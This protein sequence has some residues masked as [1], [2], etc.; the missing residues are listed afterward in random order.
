[1]NKLSI[2]RKKYPLTRYVVCVL[3]ALSV[4]ALKWYAP[5]FTNQ[6]AEEVCAIIKGDNYVF[7]GNEEIISGINLVTAK[8]DKGDVV[9]TD[10]DFTYSFYIVKSK[11]KLTFSP[12]TLTAK[13]NLKA[14]VILKEIVSNTSPAPFSVVDVEPSEKVDGLLKDYFRGVISYAFTECQKR[15]VDIFDLY[16]GFYG[17]MGKKWKENSD[18]Y[19]QNSSLEVDAKVTYY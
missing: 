1:M 2:F 3:A 7:D 8:L 6:Y 16:G 13:V 4:L 10:G 19:L 5:E 11:S 14:D 12:E 18:N 9:V 15:D 17:Q